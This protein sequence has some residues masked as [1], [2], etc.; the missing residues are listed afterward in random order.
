MTPLTL[1]RARFY[2]EAIDAD[3]GGSD[4]SSAILPALHTAL[5]ASATLHNVFLFY[6]ARSQFGCCLASH[7]PGC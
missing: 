7:S 2:I 3:Y 1:E 6:G 5:F 4:V